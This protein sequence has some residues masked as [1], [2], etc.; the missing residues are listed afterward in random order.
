[1]NLCLWRTRPAREQCP[2]PERSRG[3]AF[4]PALPGPLRCQTA[5]VAAVEEVFLVAKT[6]GIPFEE[7][8]KLP[9]Q[10]HAVA[11]C[12]LI[13]RRWTNYLGG[14]SV[15]EFSGGGHLENRG[16]PYAHE[17]RP[18]HKPR[19]SPPSRFPFQLMPR[20]GSVFLG[21][22]V[23]R[24]AS[25]SKRRF[26]GSAQSRCRSLVGEGMDSAAASAGGQSANVGE[27]RAVD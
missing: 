19:R 24:S 13:G 7:G 2:R 12:C 22:G 11:T 18:C 20:S 9:K 3:E 8:A 17:T 15:P 6:A 1:M 14:L 4:L 16:V 26:V 23:R 25:V 21:S 5:R 10:S 27:G